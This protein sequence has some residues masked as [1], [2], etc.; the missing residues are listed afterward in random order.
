MQ[1]EIGKAVNLDLYW[2]FSFNNNL[3]RRSTIL[4]EHLLR[5]K[6]FILI[7]DDLWSKFIV[8]EVG[9][10]QPNKENGCKLVLIT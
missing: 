10:P 9:I 1:I 3:I 5:M 7:I 8:E 2:E 4:F 6:K